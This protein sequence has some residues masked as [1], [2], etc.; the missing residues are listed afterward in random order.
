MRSRICCLANVSNAKAR[1]R[2]KAKFSKLLSPIHDYLRRVVRYSLAFQCRLKHFSNKSVPKYTHFSIKSHC[3]WDRTHWVWLS[4]MANVLVHLSGTIIF[5]L[6]TYTIT[7]VVLLCFCASVTNYKS[8]QK[9][10]C[11]D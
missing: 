4:D 1:E 5:E 9:K 2:A 3:V 6:G 7:H 8:P 11:T 10:F